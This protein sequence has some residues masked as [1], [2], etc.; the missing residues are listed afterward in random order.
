M[1]CLSVVLG[2]TASADHPGHPTWKNGSGLVDSF[3]GKK[4]EEDSLVRSCTELSD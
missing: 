1:Q 3:R 4:V 2:D